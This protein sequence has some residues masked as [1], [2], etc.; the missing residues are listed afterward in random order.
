ML[1]LISLTE[2]SG[3]ELGHASLAPPILFLDYSLFIFNDIIY[4]T[5]KK[6]ELYPYT[7]TPWYF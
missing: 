3:G 6:E 4:T 5:R 2:E 1:F 7:L